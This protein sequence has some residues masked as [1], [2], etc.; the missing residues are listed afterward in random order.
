MEQRM[1]NNVKI[2]KNKSVLNSDGLFVYVLEWR[3][4]SDIIITE[5]ITVDPTIYNTPD[6]S[7]FNINE[8]IEHKKQ[9]FDIQTEILIEEEVI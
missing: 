2:Y 6:E 9:V 3:L 7:K 1:L 4:D 5:K 8:I